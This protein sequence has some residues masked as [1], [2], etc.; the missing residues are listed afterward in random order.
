M[1]VI[2]DELNAAGY[3]TVR[4]NEFTEKTLWH[5]LHTRSYIGEYR[6][7]EIIVLNGLPQFVSVEL[8][9]FVGNLGEPSL[10]DKVLDY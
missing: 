8:F 9:D 10:R 3:K 5:T 2:A 4:G 1:K 6:W 7:G